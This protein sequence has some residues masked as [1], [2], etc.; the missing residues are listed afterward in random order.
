MEWLIF[1]WLGIIILT[2]VLEATSYDLISIWFSAGALVSMILAIIDTTTKLEINWVAQV[3]VF[4]IV[5]LILIL[6]LRPVTKKYLKRIDVKTNIDTIVGK[7]GIIVDAIESGERGTVKVDGVIW[8]A[9][10]NDDVLSDEKV[11]VLAIEGNKLIV[12]LKED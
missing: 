4:V 9:I 6:S 12:N 10:S 2:I 1:L 7:H 3:L 8:T 11:E 5:S